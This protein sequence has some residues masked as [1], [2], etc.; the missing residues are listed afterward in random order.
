MTEAPHRACR[1]ILDLEADT[2]QDLADALYALSLR[3]EMNDLGE[4]S[5]SG[6]P[7][8][9]YIATY[10]QSHRP[11]HEEY[12]EALTQHLKEKKA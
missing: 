11:T 7:S 10:T 6:G 12:V 1:L 4:S 8:S 5:V 3:I 9:G 2:P